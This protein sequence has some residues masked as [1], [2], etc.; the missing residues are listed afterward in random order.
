[1]LAGFDNVA[2][3]RCIGGPGERLGEIAGV[4]GARMILALGKIGGIL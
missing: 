4:L 3:D 1:M 2:F